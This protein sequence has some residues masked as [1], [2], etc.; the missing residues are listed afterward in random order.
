MLK[1]TIFSFT[2]IPQ[3]IDE[4]IMMPEY[5]LKC[6]FARA[7]LTAIVLCQY[8]TSPADTIEMLNHLSG[9]CVLSLKETWELEK[10]L[11]G[12]EYI[13]Y[14]FFAGATPENAY[15]PYM[16]YM[17]KVTGTPFSFREKG[18]AALYIKS[19]GDQTPRLIKM[20]MQES[21]SEWFLWYQD[22]LD[23]ID[24]PKKCDFYD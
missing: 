11:Q 12:R 16:P 18:F 1:N 17:I 24:E 21:T 13:P 8:S 4:L 3:N 2:Y 5:K 10:K 20:R 6:P 7:A 19:S 22:L 23:P 9:P 14:S 15:E